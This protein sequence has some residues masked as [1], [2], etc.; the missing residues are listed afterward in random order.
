MQFID[1]DL[2]ATRLA[3]SLWYSHAHPPGMNLLAGIGLKL[4]G[5]NASMF[6]Q[7]CFQA[8]G[9]ALALAAFALTLRLT[10]QRWVALACTAAIVWSP[11]FVLYENWFMYSFCEA[12]L[13]TVAGAALYKYLD[14]RK[15]VW[16]VALFGSLAALALTRSFFHIG[17]LALVVGYVAIAA[18]G[19]RRRTF[20]AAALPLLLVAMW[21]GKNAYLFGTFSASTLFGIGLSNISTLAVSRDELAPLVHA[22]V[23]SPFALVSRYEQTDLLFSSQQLPPTE[24]PV[25]DDVRKASGAYNFNSL[26]MVAVNQYYTRDALRV[27]RIFPFSYVVGWLIANRLFF[28][29]PQMN[30]YFTHPNRAAALPFERVFNAILYGVPA[31]PSYI[32][33]PH[34]GFQPP[35]YLLEVNT[36]SVSIALWVLVFVFGYLQTRR[37]LLATEDS[38][39]RNR[40]LVLGFILF[41]MLY[42]YT[43]GTAFELGENYRYRF[44]VEPLFFA[45]LAMIATDVFRK[46][47]AALRRRRAE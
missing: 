25:L 20:G 14:G 17:W 13:L 6:F 21:Y 1:P 45:A 43:V 41:N 9:A 27:A 11:A 32:A 7:V 36:S 5:S 4:F 33:Q 8:L 10:G 42:V 29:P 16:A 44:A 15:T 38:A 23:L 35:P 12:S 37:G 31:V 22:G 18:R 3:E 39:D 34:F 40:A 26:Q 28:S 24:I 47:S 19:H 46:A 2:L 30:L